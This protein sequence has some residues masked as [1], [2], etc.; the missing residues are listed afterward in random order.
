MNITVFDLRK[1]VKKVFAAIDRNKAATLTH[2]GKKKPVI[3]SCENY[4]PR[5][6]AIDHEAF[7]IWA[8]REESNDIGRFVCNLR[9]G[10][11]S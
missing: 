3:V 9:K 5:I 8:D 4:K 1:N 10:R 2:H 11:D 7:G 6:S